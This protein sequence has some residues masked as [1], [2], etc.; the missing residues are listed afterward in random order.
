MD[1]SHSNIDARQSIFNQVGRDMIH[2]QTKHLHINIF[3]RGSQRTPHPIPTDLP[4]PFQVLSQGSLVAYRSSDV[5]AAVDAALGLINQTV[6]LLRDCRNSSNCC[7]NL[8]LEIH[9]LQQTLTLARST[10]QKYDKTPLAHSLANIIIPEVQRCSLV[11]QELIDSIDSPWL[12]IT[13]T[14][15]GGFWRRIWWSVWVGGQSAPLGKKLS[16]SRQLIQGLLMALHS[17]VLVVI[18]PPSSAES[19]SHSMIN[20]KCCMD[21]S[22]KRIMR[23]LC[24]PPDVS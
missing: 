6:E 5:V 8:I 11:L 21:G 7:L 20:E 18:Q 16:R 24:I 15:V 22:R 13:I 2:H 23:K 14:S 17:Y 19:Q 9:S 10:V 12:D 4:R 3:L 1:V